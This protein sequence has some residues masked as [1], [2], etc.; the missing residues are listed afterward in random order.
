MLQPRL[1]ILPEAQRRLWPELADTPGGFTLY[2][3]TAIALRLGHRAS[4]D[5]DFFSFEPFVPRDLLS[6][7]PY[8]KGAAILQSSPNTLT[9]RVERS[10]PVQLSYF[11]GLRVG[12][13][14]LAEPVAGP[15]FPVASLL[16]LGGLKVAVVTQRAEAKDYIDVHAL[17]AAG[18]SLPQMLA[19]AKVIYADEFNP[20][21]ALK[22]LAYHAEPAI[23]RLPEHL[24]RDLAAAV[25]AVDLNRL[26]ALVPVRPRRGAP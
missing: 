25:K 5:F 9:C 1:D 17:I 19:A 16:D 24:R 8:L 11:G 21:I 22:A 20:L 4:V 26:P 7:I 15:G 3:G 13:V 12:Q 23:A 6:A 18:I 14:A 2:G 10:G